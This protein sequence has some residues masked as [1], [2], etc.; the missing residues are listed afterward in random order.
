[1]NRSRSDDGQQAVI[2]AAQDTADARP[3]IAHEL[4]NGGAVERPPAD[5]SAF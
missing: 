1:V 5:A 3:R 4:A 2:L